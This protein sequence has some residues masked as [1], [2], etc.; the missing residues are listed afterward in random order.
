[1]EITTSFYS[2]GTFPG[3]F[4][5]EINEKLGAE[6]NIYWDWGLAKAVDGI[7]EEQMP[8]HIT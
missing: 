2:T 1:M 7:K 8:W 6:K 5:D 3:Q 4:P